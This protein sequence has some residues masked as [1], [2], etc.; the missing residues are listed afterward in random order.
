MPLLTRL[1]VP[2]PFLT[3]YQRT[4]LYEKGHPPGF[5]FMLIYWNAYQRADKAAHVGTITQ[6]YST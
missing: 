3:L 6:T 4:L 2:L 1:L 5:L